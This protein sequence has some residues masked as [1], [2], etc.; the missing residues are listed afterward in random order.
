MS[1]Y[2]N[3]M[4]PQVF[5]LGKTPRQ[6]S[7]RN[8]EVDNDGSAFTL[9]FMFALRYGF[10]PTEKVPFGRL[11][12]Y[13]AVGPAIVFSH[14][15]LDITVCRVTAGRP[16]QPKSVK[17]VVDPDGQNSVDIALAVETGARLMVRKNVSVEL[18]FKWRHVK[19]HYQFEA[20]NGFSVWAGVPT[21]FTFDHNPTFNF[22]SVQAGAAYHF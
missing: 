19:P 5:I 21:R 10:F 14:Q 16:G 11:Q 20:F 13:I 15:D 17:Y 2:R 7:G 1:T 3:G 22:I 4:P 8:P 12:P 6:C 9:A 18:T